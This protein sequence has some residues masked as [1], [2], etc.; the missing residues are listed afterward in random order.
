LN[1]LAAGELLIAA[2]CSAISAG[3]E[4]LAYR[5]ELNPAQAQ[6]VTIE[7][8]GTV[9]KYPF[10]YGYA[11]VGEVVAVGDATLDAWIGRRVFSFQP[12]QTHFIVRPGQV[13]EVPDDLPAE[14]AVF[15]PNMETAVNFMMDGQPIIGERVAVFGQGVVGLLTTALL[16]RF[17]LECLMTFDPDAGRR[18]QSAELG[19]ESVDPNQ[20]DRV[21]HP[22]FDLIFE[23]SGSPAALNQAIQLAAPEARIVVGSWYGKKPVALN[24]GERFHRD[25]LQLISSQ[26]SSLAARHRARWSKERRTDQAWAQIRSLD[27]IPWITHRFPLDQAASAYRLLDEPESGVLQVI[28]SSSS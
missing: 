3:T 9:F 25:R 1:D 16:S 24:L 6:D 4:L 7:A 13:L 20:L 22:E 8:L 14:A 5:G 10:K 18:K 17:P 15:L 26:V 2:E 11:A 28:F 23:L 21:R 27:P 12:H 19:A